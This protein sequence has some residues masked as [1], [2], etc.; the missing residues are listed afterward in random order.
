ML[1]MRNAKPWIIA[2]TWI[3]M[4]AGAQP[5]E[6]LDLTAV[7]KDPRWKI[8]G[9]TTS[10]V[11]IKGKHALKISEGAGMGVVW[12]DGYDFSNGVIEADMLGR[13][14][15]VQG[16]FLGVAFRVVD[17]QTHDAVYF[18]PFNFRVADP[19]R[20]SHAVQ[21]V[22]DPRWPWQTLRSE[23]PGVYEQAV[24]PEPDG[25]EWFHARIVVARPKVSVF[26]NGA[27][28]PCLTVKELSDRARGSLGLWVGEGSGGHFANLRVTRTLK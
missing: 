3:A 23:H 20:H 26:V 25:D 5:P 15:P 14:Q 1:D 21:Y 11:D 10:I 9:R 16:S 13:S 19:V 12:L 27:S 6:S 18:R 28:A 7:G 17:G 8:A 24:I 22:S 4:R 2:L